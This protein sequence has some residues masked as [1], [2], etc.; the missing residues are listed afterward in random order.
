[1]RKPKTIVTQRATRE[2]SF[3]DLVGMDAVVRDELLM[4]QLTD[5][6]YPLY[7]LARL[8]G[9]APETLR[10]YRFRSF[11]CS[12]CPPRAAPLAAAAPRERCAQ[13]CCDA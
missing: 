7:K 11:L 12:P 10:R 8:H 1:M 13:C 5:Q 4:F 3:G 6:R 9:M 2:S